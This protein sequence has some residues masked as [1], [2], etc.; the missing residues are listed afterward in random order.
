MLQHVR[1]LCLLLLNNMSLYTPHFPLLLTICVISRFWLQWIMQLWTFIYVFGYKYSFILDKFLN[2]SMVLQVI[3]YFLFNSLRNCQTIF[4]SGC[5]ILQSYQHWMRMPFPHPC[6]HLLLLSLPF[7]WAK[8]RRS[9]EPP[10]KNPF[11]YLFQFLELH[12]FSI[13]GPMASYPC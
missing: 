8:N 1:G 11:P 7:P 6:Q 12:Y 9:A 5:Y 4:Q 13:L 3:W 10:E 2:K